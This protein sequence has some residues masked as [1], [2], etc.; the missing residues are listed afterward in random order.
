MYTQNV[1]RISR[2]Q[3]VKVPWLVCLTSV[4]YRS[5]SYQCWN[6]LTCTRNDGP[7]NSDLLA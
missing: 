7:W 3:P 2:I 5:N 1:I 6:F 4:C